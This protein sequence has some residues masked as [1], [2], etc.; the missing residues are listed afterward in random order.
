MD[1]PPI[2]GAG[3]RQLRV[4]KRNKGHSFDSKFGS[5]LPRAVEQYPTVVEVIAAHSDL[6]AFTIGPNGDFR[7]LARQHVWVFH[8]RG[9]TKR[10]PRLV[11]TDG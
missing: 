8:G 7:P 2:V 3:R 5:V 4:R 10:H 9:L 6:E 11:A 1:K